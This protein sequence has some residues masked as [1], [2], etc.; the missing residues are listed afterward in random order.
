MSAPYSYEEM[1]VWTGAINPSTQHVH[2]TQLSLFFRRHLLNRLYSIFEWDT[3]ETWPKNFF[4]WALFNVGYF[5]IFNTTEY[6]TIPMNCS[7]S[8]YNVFY[9]PRKVLVANPCLSNIGN[10]TIDEDCVLIRLNPDYGGAADIVSYYG[11]MAALTAQTMGMNLTN[12][13]LSYAFGAVNK[14]GAE[15]MKEMYDQ[16]QAGNPA[17]FYDSKLKNSNGEVPWDS[18]LGRVGENYIAD[19]LQMLLEQLNDDFD[20][21]IGIPNQN[22]R[23]NA[24]VLQDELHANDVSTMTTAK[25]WLETITEG[26]EKANRMFGL[27]LSVKFR[28]EVEIDGMGKQIIY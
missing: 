24:H 6:G 26:L 8:G 17:V 25:M 16:V 19:K 4:Q 7:L 18:F 20:A 14:A 15:T 23:K 10:L 27:D 5:C 11:D 12:S 28:N 9:Q 21:A 2:D 22:V 3:P 13:K 1:N